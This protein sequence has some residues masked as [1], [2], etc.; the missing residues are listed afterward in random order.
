MTLNKIALVTGASSG[1]GE[2]VSRELIKRGWQVIG[3][4]LSADKL[5][6]ILEVKWTPKTGQGS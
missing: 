1:I 2:A 6:K 4:A 3:V 5:S